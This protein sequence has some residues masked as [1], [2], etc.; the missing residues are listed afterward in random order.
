MA[1]TA[2]TLLCAL[3]LSCAPCGAWAQ[4]HLTATSAQ[5]TVVLDYGTPQQSVAVLLRPDL[6]SCTMRKGGTLR[7]DWAGIDG[8]EAL[9][10]CVFRYAAALGSPDRVHGWLTTHGFDHETTMTGPLRGHQYNRPNIPILTRTYRWDTQARGLLFDHSPK[11][12]TPSDADAIAI[13]L[14]LSWTKPGGELVEVAH[15][16]QSRWTK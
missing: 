1:R 13:T 5:E 10:V 3:A 4:Q 16:V 7:L 6:A 9:D 15:S 12:M 11:A 8:F 2:L 14:V